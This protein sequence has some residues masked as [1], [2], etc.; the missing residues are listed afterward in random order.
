MNENK[1]INYMYI[2]R[3]LK[4]VYIFWHYELEYRFSHNFIV[5]MVKL[6]IKEPNLRKNRST[7]KWYK[8]LRNILPIKEQI[9][10]LILC[11]K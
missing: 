4:F 5:K 10:K 8:I 7:Q 1:Y 3:N 2:S 6:N 9:K 11:L